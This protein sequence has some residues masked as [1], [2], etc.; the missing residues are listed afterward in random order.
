VKHVVPPH[1]DPLDVGPGG[2]NKDPNFVDIY[3]ARVGPFKTRLEMKTL[4]ERALVEETGADFAYLNP[5]AVR[6]NFFEGPLLVRHVWNAMPF[7]DY[8]ATGTIVGSELPAFLLEERGLDPER[9]YRFA[10]IDFVVAQWHQR[11]LGAIEVEHGELFRDL[12]IR[13]IGEQERLD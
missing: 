7:E 3:P 13:W 10:T 11:G 6:S 12:L 9:E 5:G 1:P 2:K 8:I 4:F